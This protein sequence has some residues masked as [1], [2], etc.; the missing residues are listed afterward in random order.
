MIMDIFKD[1]WP[2]V[3]SQD[4]NTPEDIPAYSMV[5]RSIRVKVT[6]ANLSK[7]NQELRQT[8]VAKLALPYLAVIYAEKV[9]EK[10]KQ[11]TEMKET[12]SMTVKE[13]YNLMKH[14]QECS[15]SL[16]MKAQPISAQL[17]KI[18]HEIKEATNL[19]GITQL[20][21]P[22]E[23]L[24]T[25]IQNI[26]E[27][28]T[29]TKQVLRELRQLVKQKAEAVQWMAAEAGPKIQE[30]F[31]KLSPVAGETKA[32]KVTTET[33]QLIREWKQAINEFAELNSLASS[34]VS[35]LGPFFGQNEETEK[36]QSASEADR[37]MEATTTGKD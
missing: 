2:T 1:L 21:N 22:E 13:A 34:K 37:R 9:T 27:H 3:I 10:Q 35:E 6:C 16:T 26:E 12:L 8:L 30:V 14:L 32:K 25:R 24:E 7:E 11:V 17:Q 15:N 36:T 31:S 29:A 4:N 23:V 18:S 19:V 28:F 5:E 20:Y 33:E